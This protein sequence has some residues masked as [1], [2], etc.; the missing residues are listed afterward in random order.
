MSKYLR[1][2]IFI[3]STIFLFLLQIKGFA[4]TD[5]KDSLNLNEAIELT[6]NKVTGIEKIGIQ[7][8]MKLYPNPNYGNFVLE[9]KTNGNSRTD[10]EIYNSTGFLLIRKEKITDG[11][12]D[13]NLTKYPAG[14]YYLK[15]YSENGV[16]TLKFLIE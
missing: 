1:N 14:M 11:T 4:Q 10:L 7:P 6:I 15:V 13:F 3:I 12:L 9:I 8:E 2:N 16:H 5:K